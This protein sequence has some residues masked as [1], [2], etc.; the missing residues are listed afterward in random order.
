M[1]S[2]KFR[3]SRAL[4]FIALAAAT[5]GMAN[6]STLDVSQIARVSAANN[7]GLTFAISNYGLA[8]SSHMQVFLNGQSAATCASTTAQGKAFAM[9][10][11][12]A[13]G[14][15]VQCRGSANT[16]SGHQ[17]SITVT[18]KDHAGV[19]FTHTAHQGYSTAAVPSQAIGGILFGAVFN[20]ANSN[21]AFDAGET[22]SYSYSV[23]NF[24]NTALTGIVVSDDLLTTISCPQS[25]LAVGA[26]MVCT[27]T[28][29]L[30]AGEASI[31]VLGNDAYLDADQAGASSSDSVI[32]TST[33]AAEIRA[34]KSPILSADNDNNDVAGT[35]DVVT[36]TF[37]L[38]NSGSLALNPVNMTEADPSRIDGSITCNPTTLGGASFGGLGAG[39]LAVGDTV[40]CTATYTISDNDVT[41]GRA[42]N[43]VNIMGQPPFGGAASGSAASAFVVPPPPAPVIPTYTPVP[44]NGWRAM[45]L[46]MLGLL[47]AVG[48]TATQ[49]KRQGR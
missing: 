15:S 29:V 8:P 35:G 19:P 39:A 40:L 32:R 46:L 31:G 13:A 37:A 10:G 21:N 30:T 14:D 23:F 33:T 38:K 5:V 20:D 9:N 27:G 12:L 1:N 17:T 45:L 2:S 49:R 18:G 22:I 7:D 25:T 34:L 48:Y 4:L 42:N 11:A 43:L 26:A 3:S 36:Y 16:A 44:V 6:A 47:V 24:G 28:H 41:S